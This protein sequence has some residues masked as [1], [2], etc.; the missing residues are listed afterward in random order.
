MEIY[1]QE[2]IIPT[3]I[4]YCVTLRM[5]QFMLVADQNTYAASGQ[6][7]EAAL[8]GEGF[9]VK[10]VILQGDEIIADEHYLMQLF[11][12]AD[13][14]DRV[15]L[16][17]GSGT[18]TDIT[19]FVSHRARA[20]FISLPTAPSVD[21]F[22]SI[23]A[24]L[25][26]ER[27]KRTIICQPPLALFADLNVL[28][29]AP[30][31]MLAAGF[32]D[33][34]GKYTAAADWELGHLLWNEPYNPE[35]AARARQAVE[36]C[37]PHAEAIGRA[38]PAGVRHLMEALIETGFCMLEF[39]E[40]RP[41]SGF[42]H[43]LS[44]FWEMKLLQER[45]SPILHGAKVGTG[46]VITAGYY[47]QIRQMSQSEA[48]ERLKAA[49]LPDRAAEIEQIRAVYGPVAGQV[50]DLQ[51]DFLDMTAPAFDRLKQQIIDHWPAIRRIAA[52]VPAPATLTDLL[53]RV[54]AAT[55]PRQLGLQADEIAAATR[56]AHYYRNRFTI[57]KLARLL[58]IL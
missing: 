49:R 17:V 56:Y 32:G 4:Q 10:T 25:V 27:V 36:N 21:G 7:I 5:A 47:D 42:E 29:A 48:A 11:L 35:I 58:G 16:A 51:A 45:R 54:G 38:S 26:I 33:I 30:P 53:Q 15:Y 24:P 3:L 12:Q 14:L 41:A 46:A 22:T 52:T 44:H 28:S 1:I 31:P 6:A 20:A 19:R 55:D 37:T 2:N 23:G 50:I 57:A 43:H 40:S 13:N 34:V 8:Q 9:N 39:G 18:L